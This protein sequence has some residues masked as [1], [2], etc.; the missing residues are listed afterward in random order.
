MIGQHR[1][2]L[3]HKTRVPDGEGGFIVDWA[4]LKLV[5]L[6]VKPISSSEMIKYQKLTDEISHI[7]KMRYDPTIKSTYRIKFN[8][9]ILEIKGK[10]LNVGELNREL[11]L[12]CLETFN[13]QA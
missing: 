1:A 12:T 5:W 2:I 8:N 9:R 3:Q 11:E 13:L 7:V 10:P 4:D 6:T